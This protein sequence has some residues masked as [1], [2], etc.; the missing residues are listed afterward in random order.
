MSRIS[1][2]RSSWHVT[3]TAGLVLTLVLLA[4][5]E[6]A[7]IV[8]GTETQ[9]AALDQGSDSKAR[10]DLCHRNDEGSY[11]KIT[12][13]EPAVQAHLNHG[14][15]FIGDPVPGNPG[16]SFGAE[17]E[18][19]P[20][21]E[22]VLPNVVIV[23]QPSE[24]A[25]S[26]GASGASFGPEPSGQSGSFAV[27]NDGSA[28]PTLGCNPLIGF[29]AGAIAIADRG[30]CTFVTKALNAQ[31][32]GAIALIVVNSVLGDPI[33]MGGAEPAVVIPSVMVRLADG[34]I[35]KAGL[36]ATGSVDQHP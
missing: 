4:S 6:S 17:C 21:P 13:A 12:V 11:H 23:D 15:G 26:Y 3:L 20:D 28:V 10:V 24:A 34:G 14:D 35:I 29:P 5:C 36:P 9:V 31:A 22:D 2:S 8:D 7:A 25:G 19:V 18:A 33:T 27:V 16:Y 30:A 32:A 1:R